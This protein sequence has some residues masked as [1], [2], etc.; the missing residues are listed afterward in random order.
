MTYPMILLSALGFFLTLYCI[1]YSVEAWQKQIR[2]KLMRE[3]REAI[4]KIDKLLEE[5]KAL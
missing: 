3:N 1:G 4:D 5:I 2:E